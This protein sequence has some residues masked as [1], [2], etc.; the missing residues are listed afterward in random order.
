MT[1]R[2]HRSP[3]L[4]SQAS[5]LAKRRHL[6]SLGW[7]SSPSLPSYHLEAADTLRSL[8]NRL[9]VSNAPSN[10]SR[11]LNCYHTNAE[12]ILGLGEFSKIYGVIAASKW[13]RP[14]TDPQIGAFA[15]QLSPLRIPTP[16]QLWLLYGVIRQASEAFGHP[17]AHA[18]TALQNYL[19]LVLWAQYERP[20][21]TQTAK[22]TSLAQGYLAM[23]AAIMSTAPLS[24]LWTLPTPNPDIQRFDGAR[25]EIMP[26]GGY[27]LPAL[28][29]VLA[30]DNA[31]A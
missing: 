22:H 24:E 19:R 15:E 27:P 26:A 17:P 11:R 21:S 1:T 3:P 28:C 23:C 20:I 4:P 5:M 8:L 30:S 16:K 29:E 6:E 7:V 31:H 10:L 13:G 2:L 25:F 18:A 9:Y 14:R 12:E